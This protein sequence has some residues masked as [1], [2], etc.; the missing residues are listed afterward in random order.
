MQ[1]FAKAK[2]LNYSFLKPLKT[3]EDRIKTCLIPSLSYNFKH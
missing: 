3:P 2:H 1:V